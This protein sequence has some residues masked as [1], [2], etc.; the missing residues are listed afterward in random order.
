M[1]E[2]R[3]KPQRFGAH[4]RVCTAIRYPQELK[5]P[6]VPSLSTAEN[7]RKS[8]ES[9]A[10][11]CETVKT[12]CSVGLQHCYSHE[13]SLVV[14]TVFLETN[15]KNAWGHALSWRSEWCRHCRQ[16]QRFLLIFAYAPC[17]FMI[18]TPI[19]VKHVAFTVLFTLFLQGL[20]IE[21][22]LRPLKHEA[23]GMMILPTFL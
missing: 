6:V 2:V 13:V 12:V 1:P 15:D 20:N 11:D 19:D 14:Y 5:S 17:D 16:L 23:I 7:V 4:Q 18:C 9:M 10:S 8:S 22:I 3:M 21:H